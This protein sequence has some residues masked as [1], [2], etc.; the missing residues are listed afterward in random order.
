MADLM[1]F[2]CNIISEFL[3]HGN[4]TGLNDCVCESG[5]MGDSCDRPDCLQQNDCNKKGY[6]E[7]PG[8]CNCEA[9]WELPDCSK[10]ASTNKY[11][12]KFQSPLYGNVSEE[13]HAGTKV[14][15]SK[16]P[17]A[18]DEDRTGTNAKISYSLAEGTLFTIDPSTGHLRTSRVLNREGDSPVNASVFV[19]IT[20]K[21]N[22][23]PSKSSTQMIEINILDKNDNHPVFSKCSLRDVITS[24]HIDHSAN[25]E[26]PYVYVTPID[27]KDTHLATFLAEDYDSDQNGL[28]TYSFKTDIESY[29][30]FTI[31]NESGKLTC[32][33]DIGTD[34]IHSKLDIIARDQGSP[35]KSTKITLNIRMVSTTIKTIN[36]QPWTAPTVTTLPTTTTT[37][38][39]CPCL[40]GGQCQPPSS[41]KCECAAG[42]LGDK[43]QTCKYF[44]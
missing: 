14:V 27:E 10:E 4:C 9:G 21:D 34:F 30:M 31:H 29:Q 3:G 38:F 43:C 8:V 28:V 23:F 41:S 12:P 6:C 37:P 35:T 22:G 19:T 16:F 33:K 42:Y 1:V 44:L 13:E 5:W 7:K 17:L 39:I 32:K 20:A 26:L 15:F 40:N 25:S 11:S 2:L 36:L 18:L 24:T